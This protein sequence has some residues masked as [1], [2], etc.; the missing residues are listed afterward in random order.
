VLKIR[1]YAK[2]QNVNLTNVAYELEYFDQAH[3][4]N[5]FKRF[6]NIKPTEYVKLVA[7][8]PNDENCP[9]FYPFSSDGYIFTMIRHKELGLLLQFNLINS[10]I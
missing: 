1:H 7:A 9:S 4:N 3:F 5:D 6:T 10:K 2:P 8:K